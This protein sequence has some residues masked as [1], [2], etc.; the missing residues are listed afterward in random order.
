MVAVQCDSCWR[1]CKARLYISRLVS[2]AG[3]VVYKKSEKCIIK[4]FLIQKQSF[5]SCS[6]VVETEPIICVNFL[7]M[8]T[9]I[10]GVSCCRFVSFT[11]SWHTSR[12]CCRFMLF[13]AAGMS[14]LL[15][16]ANI[17]M[18]CDHLLS[19][20]L[21]IPCTKLNGDTIISPNNGTTS[22]F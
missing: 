14:T 21:G 7:K 9:F 5:Y 16:P 19:S 3:L 11:P 10:F 4:E 17:S 6:Q 22:T 20:K 2:S 1:V 15:S 13:L 18:Q 8:P 12:S